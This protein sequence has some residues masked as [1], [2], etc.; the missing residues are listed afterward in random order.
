MLYRNAVRFEDEIYRLKSALYD[1]GEAIPGA[2]EALEVSCTTD[3]GASS[4]SAWLLLLAAAVFFIPAY[5]V[6]KEDFAWVIFY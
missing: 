1:H 5:Y 3:T 2:L 6:S 4:W